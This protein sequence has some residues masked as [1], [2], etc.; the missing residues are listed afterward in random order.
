VIALRRF[1]SLLVLPLA[2]QL[3]LAVKAVACVYQP[4]GGQVMATS[5]QSNGDM[6][7]MTMPD[8]AAPSHSANSNAPSPSPCDRP[9][10]PANCQ[11]LAACSG[12][13]LVPDDATE[14]VLI[15]PTHER[16]VPLHVIAPASRTDGPEP[17]PPRL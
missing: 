7:G 3:V 4:Q 11:P 1:G 16:A 5:A 8:A 17:P 9:F 6:G 14:R 10:G 15:A 12:A 13:A 2:F